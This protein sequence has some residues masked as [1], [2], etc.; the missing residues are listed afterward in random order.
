VPHTGSG[1]GGAKMSEDRA[2]GGSAEVGIANCEETI[3]T[4]Y[5]YL[6][7]ELT[8]ERRRAIAAHLDFCGP[9]LDI[10]GFEA[11]L[12]RV[13]ADHCRDHVPEQLRLR[14]SLAIHH[15]AT[16]DVSQGD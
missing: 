7:G 4:L 8:D 5:H 6:D 11:E 13:I 1:I 10:V 9:C 16:R 2:L 12:R 15:E 14:I 3:H